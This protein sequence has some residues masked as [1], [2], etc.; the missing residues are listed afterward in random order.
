MKNV[1]NNRNFQLLFMGNLVSQ[2]G[3]SFFGF[4][5]GW[6]ILTLTESPFQAGL[7][8][9]INGLIQ[10]LLVPF[11]SVYADRWHKG[12]IL[13]AT[14]LVRGIFILLAGI[15]IYQF[16]DVN[17][18]IAVLYLNAVIMAIA[19]AFFSPA[20]MAIIPEIV[21]DEHLREA[22]SLNSFVNSI[23]QLT[24]VLLA[25]FTYALL[26]IVG[27]FILTGVAFI[28]SAISE[29]FIRL[30][31]Q[32]S[33]IKSDFKSY[34]NDLSFGL[35]YLLKTTGLKEMLILIILLNFSIAPVFSNIYPYV[36]NIVLNRPPFDLSLA[37]AAL[38]IGTLIGGVSVGILSKNISIKQ[39][40][41]GGIL[42]T[43][44]ILLGHHLWLV[45]GAE[46]SL[47]Y[48]LFFP[49]FLAILFVF[50]WVNMWI[51]IPFNTGLTK[52][53]EPAVRG[54]VLGLVSTVAQGLIPVAIFLTGV[55]LEITSVR[56]VLIILTVVGLLPFILFLKS[57]AVNELLGSLK[58][59]QQ[60]A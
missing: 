34:L 6:Y 14:D 24:G 49:F 44:F 31:H 19:H 60:T 36:F 39:A 32:K 25:G 26:G 11:L 58:E 55:L 47:S 12:R 52:A 35:K 27:I 2:I 33:E 8:I 57:K 13:F 20:S 40:M 54:R 56:I 53:I 4:A 22:M 45:M 10:T 37:S 9:A 51:N 18:I 48:S 16:N 23:Q 50:G 5:I 38:S 42:A 28:L 59:T 30:N 41:K 3:Q 17:I 21:G 1:L 46:A 29:L 15:L 7:F 43:F